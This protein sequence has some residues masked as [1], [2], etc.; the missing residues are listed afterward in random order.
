MKKIYNKLVRD[1]I[2]QII[3][4]SGN[5][6]TYKILDEAEYFSYLDNK[7]DE[8]VKEFHDSHT[9]EELADILEVII[10]LAESSGTDEDEL[11]DIRN[12]KAKE[13]GRFEKKILLIDTTED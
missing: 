3:A 4:D 13:R 10:S 7:L 12:R 11:F 6:C 9:A 8:E 2:P 1:K 5:C